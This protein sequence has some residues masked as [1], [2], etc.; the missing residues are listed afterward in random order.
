MI[1]APGPAQKIREL[2]FSKL[3]KHRDS[4]HIKQNASSRNFSYF[5]RD[6]NLIHS[7]SSS[8]LH[9]HSQYSYSSTHSL[10][11]MTARALARSAPRTV[12]RLSAIAARP[13]ARPSLVS[14]CAPLRSQIS[15]FST[16]I[17]RREPAGS[18]DSELSAKLVSEIT[19]ETEMKENEPEPASVKDF[20]EN[21]PFQIVDTPGQ[22]EVSL[23]R[24]Y[25]NEK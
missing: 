4:V 16:S 19:F 25:G 13:I 22:Q 12:A 6:A 11:M 3:V 2:P 10:K 20:L 15:A 7:H 9:C 18:V 17:F 1:R 8:A 23:K 24:I 5:H 21:S 14:Q